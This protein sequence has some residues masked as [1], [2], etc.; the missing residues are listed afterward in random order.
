M[1]YVTFVNHIDWNG[2][3]LVTAVWLAVSLG[4]TD[5]TAVVFVINTGTEFLA[6]APSEWWLI[7]EISGYTGLQGPPHWHQAYVGSR[8]SLTDSAPSRVDLTGSC[9]YQQLLLDY[10]MDPC[11]I[12]CYVESGIIGVVESNRGS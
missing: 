4:Q 2:A 12:M 11:W 7:V 3:A 1:K 9:D 6:H 5:Q 10:S 8:H